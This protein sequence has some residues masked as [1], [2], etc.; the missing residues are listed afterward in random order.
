MRRAPLRSEIENDRLDYGQDG[1]P[2][3]HKPEIKGRIN[4]CAV[5]NWW[6]RRKDR[7]AQEAGYGWAYECGCLAR[8]GACSDP[9]CPVHGMR[10]MRFKKDGRAGR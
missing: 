5:L 8:A 10:L 1:I 4:L 6:K 7:K 3:K 9:Y 2:K